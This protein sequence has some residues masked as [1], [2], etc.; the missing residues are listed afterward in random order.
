MW[1]GPQFAQFDNISA[2]AFSYTFELAN[3]D[4]GG[5]LDEND[6]GENRE[7][8]ASQFRAQNAAEKE[9]ELGSGVCIDQEEELASWHSSDTEEGGRN[10]PGLRDEIQGQEG[11]PSQHSPRIQSPAY[12]CPS[13]RRPDLAETM[14]ACDN[15]CT[16][17]EVW[18]HLSCV[19]L[20]NTPHPKESWECQDCVTRDSGQPRKRKSRIQNSAYRQGNEALQKPKKPSLTQ[21]KAK[22]ER[23]SDKEQNFVIELMQEII[24]EK[25]VHETEK[26]WKVISDRLF[27]RRGLS[28][29]AGSIKNYW[30]RHLRSISNLDERVK[31]K[32]DK[33][34]TSVMTNEQRKEARQKRKADGGVTAE[35]ILAPKRR[36]QAR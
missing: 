3:Q 7:E 9:F 18:Y 31:K 2:K 28:R 1:F 8:D 23:W 34:I 22:K 15:H 32:P 29:P 26:K 25:E 27:W 17:P 33:M 4:D 35:S 19:G 16:E 24:D 12:F 20:P 21:K 13:C 11:T 30:N 14:V 6:D 10:R 36:R 5:L